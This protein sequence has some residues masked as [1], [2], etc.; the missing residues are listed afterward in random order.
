MLLR[1]KLRLF[2]PSHRL[3]SRE[4]LLSSQPHPHHQE[5]VQLI[6]L[7]NDVMMVMMVMVMMMMIRMTELRVAWR[8]VL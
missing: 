3:P 2:L 1:L 8:F 5:S 7:T 6:Q 4:R